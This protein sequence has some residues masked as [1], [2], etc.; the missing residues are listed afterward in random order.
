M[1]LF[2]PAS[3]I[4]HRCCAETVERMFGQNSGPSVKQ[5]QYLCACLNLAY[6]IADVDLTSK[7][8]NC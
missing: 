4:A 1:N 3:N 8:I 7:S 2:H 6:Q 5:L